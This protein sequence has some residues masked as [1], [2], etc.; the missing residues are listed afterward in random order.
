MGFSHSAAEQGSTHSEPHLSLFKC[1]MS[2]SAEAS[3]GQTISVRDWL[4]ADWDVRKP[5]LYSVLG[6]EFLHGTL[7]GSASGGN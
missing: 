2:L 6:T 4:K 3:P 5:S 7:S 1:S